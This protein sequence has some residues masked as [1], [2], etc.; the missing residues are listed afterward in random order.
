MP[1]SDKGR[2]LEVVL[3][4]LDGIASGRWKVQITLV[5]KRD[6]L[7]EAFGAKVSPWDEAQQTAN[8]GA[9]HFGST[10]LHSRFPLAVAGGA[11]ALVADPRF[12]ESAHLRIRLYE[13]K[14]STSGAALRAASNLLPDAIKDNVTKE[15]DAVAAELI[16]ESKIP[17]TNILSGRSGVASDRVLGGWMPLQLK[18]APE[19][20]EDT[21]QPRLWMQMYVLPDHQE[22]LPALVEQRQQEQAKQ[23]GNIMNEE[24]VE[25]ATAAPAEADLL[26]MSDS[27]IELTAVDIPKRPDAP[28]ATQQPAHMHPALR[29]GSSDPTKR[30][31]PPK[32]R[33]N[34]SHSGG[35][36]AA[37]GNNLIEFEASDLLDMGPDPPQSGHQAEPAS[38]LDDQPVGGM[39]VA[40][41][42]PGDLTD[43]LIPSSDVGGPTATLQTSPLDATG[44]AFATPAL[45]SSTPCIAGAPAI[46]QLS[47]Q[48]LP[49]G[50]GG[51]IGPCPQMQ[52]SQIGSSA[53]GFSFVHSAVSNADAGGANPTPGPGTAATAAGPSAFGF[54]A[55]SSESKQLDLAALYASDENKP[56]A[57][58]RVPEHDYTA[59]SYLANPLPTAAASP[60]RMQEACG[61]IG[62]MGALEGKILNGLGDSLKDKPWRQ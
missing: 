27:P 53:S 48:L 1:A 8:G 58:A 7:G 47:P 19:L 23:R 14:L 40:V 54:I 28:A 4:G 36:A 9:M 50:G 39:N 5:S 45:S 59:L 6:P 62:S 57:V 38:L 37:G 34:D 25:V 32:K 55:S 21:T 24:E 46:P 30:W 31:G 29:T 42:S 33:Q 16:A 56:K 49:G 35:D 18:F 22:M 41:S 11:P 51:G 13:A 20:L 26:S 15:L 17:L 2:S 52:T 60:P 12:N 3:L 43:L 61:S 44:G 10:G